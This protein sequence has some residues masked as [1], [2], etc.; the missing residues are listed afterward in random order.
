MP[1]DAWA[2]TQE[3]SYADVT[4]SY[5]YVPDD[6]VERSFLKQWQSLP[7]EEWARRSFSPTDNIKAFLAKC[8]AEGSPH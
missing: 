5:K 4:I 3:S 6:P 8:H 2:G 1:N 7:S